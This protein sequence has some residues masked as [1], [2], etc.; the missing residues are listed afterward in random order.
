MR[1]QNLSIATAPWLAALALAALVLTSSSCLSQSAKQL[2]IGAQF[3]LGYLPLYVA[4]QNHLF[5]Q[6]MREQGLAPVPVEIVH[7]TGGP[8]INDGLLSGNFEIGS[9]GYTAMMVSW[10]KTRNAGDSRLLGVTALSSVPYDLFSTDPQLTSVKDLSR[11]RDKIGVPSVKL[12]VPAIYLEME[13]ER[14][15]GLGK[16]TAL[17]DLT[18]SLS[19]PDGAISLL[20]GGTTVN[21]YLFSPPFIQQV[22][23]KPGIRRIWS[24]NELFG[25]PATALTTWTT[26]KFQ[27]ENPKLFAAFVAATRDAITL[28]AKDPKQAA[29]IYQKAEKTKLAPELISAALADKDNLRF[30]LAPEHT[31]RIADFL[32]RIGSIK[33]KPAS[34]KDLFFPE[35]HGEHGS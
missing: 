7:V 35:I 22:T 31:E 6:R 11:E 18:V 20:S 25:S 5:E 24:S 33:S 28:I 23:G 29:A 32:A 10:D 14:L 34:W 27:R 8:Q 15:F 30:T 16:H 13:A 9:G 19:Q 4:E 1:R 12:S 3:G 21:G 17:D 26:V 2:R